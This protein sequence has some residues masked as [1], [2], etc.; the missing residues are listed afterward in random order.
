MDS[1]SSFLYPL[2]KLAALKMYCPCESVVV[3]RVSFVVRFV[4]F[5]FVF[6]LCFPIKV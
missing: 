2:S 5:I 6:F 4:I 1:I 3:V